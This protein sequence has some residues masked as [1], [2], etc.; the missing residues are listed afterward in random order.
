LDE[1]IF[2]ILQP[3][4]P[5]QSWRIEPAVLS[6]RNHYVISEFDGP[7]GWAVDA[8]SEDDQTQIIA[9]PLIVQPSLPPRYPPF[10]VF[11][12]TA[13]DSED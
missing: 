13:V 3:F 4:P 1:R 12:F 6:G 11:K 7:L 10:E 2:A 8:E 5:P 9:R